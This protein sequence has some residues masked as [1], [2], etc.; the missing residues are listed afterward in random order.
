MSYYTLSGS[1]AELTL[2]EPVSRGQTVTVSY[3]KPSGAT[4]IEDL[5][6]KDLVAFTQKAV[7]NDSPSPQIGD[8]T[9]SYQQLADGGRQTTF[10][11]SNNNGSYGYFPDL[12]Y[13]IFD[14]KDDCYGSN[15]MDQ[16]Q[17]GR[18][19]VKFTGRNQTYTKSFTESEGKYVCVE[20]VG[21]GVADEEE[22]GQINYPLW[23]SSAAVDMSKL[24]VNFTEPVKTSIQSPLLRCSRW[25]SAA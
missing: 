3:A 23:F 25:T 15:T 12:W 13:R 20:S 16:N 4:V 2:S 14:S 19:S 21:V 24:T 8:I 17:Y 1:T 6:G 7:T 11:V 18:V 10:S 22:S 9:V 5:S